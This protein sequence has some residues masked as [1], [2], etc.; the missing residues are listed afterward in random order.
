MV[1]DKLVFAG[2][3]AVDVCG[4]GAKLKGHLGGERLTSHCVDCD[5]NAAPPKLVCT[6]EFGCHTET[7]SGGIEGSLIIKTPDKE[8][9]FPRWL[10]WLHR[11]ITLKYSWYGEVGGKGS[12]KFMDTFP[13]TGDC[14]KCKKCYQFEWLIGPF[15]RVGLNAKLQGSCAIKVGLSGNVTISAQYRHLENKGACGNNNCAGFKGEGS[16]AVS[17]MADLGWFGSVGTSVTCR[18]SAGYNM[19]CNKRW[20]KQWDGCKISDYEAIQEQPSCR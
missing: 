2:G 19:Q 16:G 9:L 10:H 6:P 18:A 3:A 12:F 17:F 8:V 13:G 11:W 20:S 1:K 15:G 7:V 4:L 14:P 5:E